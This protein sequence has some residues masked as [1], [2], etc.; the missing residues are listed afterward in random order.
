VE[1]LPEHIDT[2]KA[3][4]ND[5]KASF[6][7]IIKAVGFLFET[8]GP[9]KVILSGM[10]LA[11]TAFLL[12]AVAAL[13]LAVKGLAIAI[14]VTPLGWIIAGLTALAAVAVVIYKNWDEITAAFNA[15]WG[16]VQAIFGSVVD[17]LKGIWDDAVAGFK[18]G[19][20]DGLI[21]LWDTPNPLSLIVRAFTQL[22]PQLKQAVQPAVAWAADFFGGLVPDWARNLFDL[23]AAGGGTASAAPV[24]AA[25]TGAQASV[26]RDGGFHAVVDF[27]NIPPGV[28]V[29]TE[30]S[31]APSLDLNLGYQG[32]A[33]GV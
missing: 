22:L 24:G 16:A 8:F 19:F 11:I 5:L 23:G 30:K 20:L 28:S 12:P 32:Y 29:A 14:G 33:P 26:A 3:A 21:N 13:V 2:I 18:T 10:A 7:P 4:F 6:T 9:G 25:A 17:F 27:R 1:R 31:G 15:W